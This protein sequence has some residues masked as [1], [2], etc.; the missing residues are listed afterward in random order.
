MSRNGRLRQPRALIDL[1]GTD[2]AI[3]GVTLIGEGRKRVFEPVQNLPANRVG[4][5]FDDVVNVDVSGHVVLS[6][7][8]LYRDGANLISINRDI[9]I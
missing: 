7:G 4:E 1:A 8:A 9:Q 2:A 6:A 5:G 3:N